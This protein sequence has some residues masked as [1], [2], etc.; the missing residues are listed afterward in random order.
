VRDEA[1]V[2][3]LATDPHSPSEFRVNGIVRNLDAWY[4]A[5]GVAEGDGLWLSP[6]ER[7]SIW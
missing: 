6:A 7:V 2:T 4:E 5:F 1:L 3:R